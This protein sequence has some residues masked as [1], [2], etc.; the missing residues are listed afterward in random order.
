VEGREASVGRVGVP[1]HS[2]QHGVPVPDPGHLRHRAL[3]AS[4]P[5][6]FG[7]LDFFEKMED[8]EAEIDMD[9][10]FKSKTCQ[11]WYSFYRRNLTPKFQNCAK[12]A[13]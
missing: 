8:A 3:S 6:G 9:T 10:Y 11:R 2:Q 13:F 5:P 7:D 1:A 12:R 4:C